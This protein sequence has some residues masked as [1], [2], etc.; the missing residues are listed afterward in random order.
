MSI[1]Q[2]VYTR[3]THMHSQ[4]SKYRGALLIFVWKSGQIIHFAALPIRLVHVLMQCT[5]ISQHFRMY[6]CILG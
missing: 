5:A 1:A 4:V 3:Q 2:K 6:T